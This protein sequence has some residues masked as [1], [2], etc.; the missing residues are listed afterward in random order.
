M[1]LFS[2]VTL[3]CMYYL[4][5]IEDSYNSIL[6]LKAYSHWVL[7]PAAIPFLK[8]NQVK[9]TLLNTDSEPYTVVGS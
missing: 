9:L 7:A 3:S 1:L 5:F 6:F 8:L 2:E 4:L